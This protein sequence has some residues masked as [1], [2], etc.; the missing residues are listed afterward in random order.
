M[1]SIGRRKKV[2]QGSA[3]VAPVGVVLATLALRRTDGLT[4][5]V[6]NRANI[7]VTPGTFTD[8]NLST[9]KARINGVEVACYIAGAQS[10]I[11]GGYRTI[12]FRTADSTAADN[13]LTCELFTDGGAPMARLSAGTTST[14]PVAFWDHNTA[15]ARTAAWGVYGT[16]IPKASWSLTSDGT[17]ITA[18]YEGQLPDSGSVSGAATWPRGGASYDMAVT[19]LCH[20]AA[21]GDL[22]SRRLGLQYAA[23]YAVDYVLPNKSASGQHVNAHVLRI[24]H[25]LTGDQQ[26]MDALQ[27]LAHVACFDYD[28]ARGPGNYIAFSPTTFINGV[29]DERTRARAA[30]VLTAAVAAGI[31]T[32]ARPDGVGSTYSAASYLASHIAGIMASRQANGIWA[33]SSTDGKPFMTALVCLALARYNQL[34]RSADATAHATA[35]LLCFETLYDAYWSEPDLALPYT[36]LSGGGVYAASDPGATNTYAQMTTLMGPWY[37]PVAWAAYQAG[38]SEGRTRTAKIKQAVNAA[39]EWAID[40]NSKAFDET[41]LGFP[42][43]HSCYTLGGA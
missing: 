14:N 33:A 38:S 7:P 27:Y 35:I 12:A 9:V 19:A 8:A 1:S 28:V 4:T 30:D 17:Q 18:D 40:A 42:N 31:I 25:A 32:V 41:F 21:S 3:Y 22:T 24:G 29:V 39:T 6:G 36:T 2:A 34:F 11:D 10:Q 37:E 15:A 13:T 5:S 16:L 43:G 23:S 20:Y 26:Y